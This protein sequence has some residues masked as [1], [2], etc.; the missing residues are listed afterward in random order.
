MIRINGVY[1]M[2]YL[3]VGML[4]FALA[5]WINTIVLCFSR[6][7]FRSSIWAITEY[8]FP[9]FGLV[10]PTFLLYIFVMAEDNF[11]YGKLEGC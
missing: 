2:R 1:I 10:D 5:F 11:K 3:C 4:G 6:A 7:S 8:L 9:A